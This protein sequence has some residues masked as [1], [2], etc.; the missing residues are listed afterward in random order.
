MAEI[1]DRGTSM[2]DGS[3]VVGFFSDRNDAYEAVNELSEAGFASDQIGLASRGGDAEVTEGRKQ[4]GED[5]SF[6]QKVKDVLR[7]EEHDTNSSEFRRSL[8]GMEISD[9]Q[10]DYYARGISEGGALVTVRASGR[11]EEARRILQECGAD[12]RESGFERQPVASTNAA[13]DRD[14]RVQLRGEMLQAHKE[15]VNRGEVR[16]RKEVVSENRSIEVPVTREELVI[17]RTDASGATPTGEIGSDKE[18]RVPLSEEKVTVEKKPIVTGEV[19][20]GKRQVQ[21]TQT[22]SD[23]VR[24]EEVKLDKEGDVNVNEDALRDRKDRAA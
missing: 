14:Y 2:H 10:S 17:E 3:T 16:L 12:L 4:A 6:W 18:I 11:A 15:R 13:A 20:V 8:G 23:N 24:H 9:Q 1:L 19:H 21:D 5:R 22:V 7:G